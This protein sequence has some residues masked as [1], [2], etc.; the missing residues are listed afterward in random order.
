MAWDGEFFYLFNEAGDKITLV[1]AVNPLRTWE[2]WPNTKDGVILEVG[3]HTGDADVAFFNN[4]WHIFV[5]EGPH[6]KYKLSYASASPEDFPHRWDLQK[7]IFGPYNPDQNQVWDND[8]PE[9]NNFGTGDADVALEGSTLYMTYETP[10]GIA[11]KELDVLDAEQQTLQ[12]KIEYKKGKR[13]GSSQ[14]I[15][16][17]AGVGRLDM[18]EFGQDLKGKTWRLI[19]KLETENSLES[20]LV[21]WIRLE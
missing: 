16:V 4:R 21:E 3:N 15:N 17:P 11:F 2:P 10:V 9:G 20:P 12:A 19:L 14:W 18:K 6:R 1:Y 8:N 13:T 7:L 5:D